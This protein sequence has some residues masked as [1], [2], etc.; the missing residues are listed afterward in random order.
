MGRG[1]GVGREVVEAIREVREGCGGLG[2]ECEGI[3]GYPPH[4]THPHI[5][6]LT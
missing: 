1:G 2:C 3:I 4:L 6:M 5:Q